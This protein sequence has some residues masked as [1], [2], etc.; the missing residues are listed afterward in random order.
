VPEG[1]QFLLVSA[2]ADSL[3]VRFVDPDAPAEPERDV[4]A[5]APSAADLRS[6]ALSSRADDR[7]VRFLLDE[8][9]RVRSAVEGDLQQRK[10]RA[11][12]E[13]QRADFWE[14][15][16]R[17]ALLAEAEY[18]DRLQAAFAT[19]SKLGDRLRRFASAGN[20]AG[21]LAGLLSL[22]L[23]VLQEAISGLAEDQATDVFLRIRPAAADDHTAG[24]EWVEDLA[25]MY[26][27]WARR[28]GMR[29]ERL[30]RAEHVYAVGGL[31]AGRILEPE[32]GLH[33]L[34]VP[35][36]SRD[37]ARTERVRALVQV[38]AWRPGASPDRAPAEH[39]RAALDVAPTHAEVV[40]RYRAEPAPLVRD[41]VR[42]YRTGRLDRVLAGDFDL[43]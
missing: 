5:Q 42:G 20:G 10:D 15:E 17:H 2:G 33:V 40:R 31:G 16:G 26:A 27:D 22:R 43:F 8:L 23:Y 3:Q 36:E 6:L 28:R 24:A 11:L 32:A 18:L 14:S 19:A 25:G 1:D 12:A 7:A 21:E 9:G 38:V 39:A 29:L 35:D 30:D 34:E 13:M 41:A 37:D 4:D